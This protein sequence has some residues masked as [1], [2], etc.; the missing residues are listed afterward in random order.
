MSD[1]VERALIA[2]V[3]VLLYPALVYMYKYFN[4]LRLLKQKQYVRSRLHNDQANLSLLYFWAPNCTQCGAQEKFIKDVFYELN[5][6][7][8]EVVY[9]KINARQELEAADK[10]GIMTV[11]AI[12]IFDKSGSIVSWNPGLMSKRELIKHISRRR[13]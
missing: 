11:P 9:R 13:T 7:E 10:F 5:L 2:L 6:K 1:I 4:R 12:V 8:N 3:I